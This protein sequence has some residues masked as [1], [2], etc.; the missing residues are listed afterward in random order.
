MLPYWLS[1][2]P[3]AL[4]SLTRDF[5]VD[6][7]LGP[8]LIALLVALTL[9]VG[10]RYH[11]GA[12]WMGYDSIYRI[13][14]LLDYDQLAQ[15]GDRGFFTLVWLLHSA[16]VEIWLLNLLC[17]LIFMFGLATFARQMPNPWLTVA[18]AL[19]YLIVVVA[20]SGIRQ[21]SAIGLFYMAI[22]AYRERRLMTAVGWLFAAA[23]FHASAII[24]LGVAGLS[25]T[26]NRL[27]G[28]MVILATALVGYYVLSST[29]DTYIVRYGGAQIQSSG[30]IYRV[31]MNMVA[32]VPYLLLSKRI[33]VLGDHERKFWR[34]MS[35]LSIVCLPL[36]AIVPSSTA[37]DR[38]ALYLI[39]LQTFVLT[40]LPA[41]LSHKAKN[42]KVITI[43]ILS[44][45]FFVM[46]IFLGYGV[47]SKAS[48]PYRF[49]PIFGS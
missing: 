12:D 6:R 47:N 35:W 20:M 25:F 2:F 13:T 46:T 14:A 24:M 21:A 42:V 19:P 22:V 43:A 1:F 38:L 34:N 15:F 5:R 7:R 10:L 8:V 9:F 41:V 36:L 29:F 37:L 23:T 31:L 44:Y 48:I 11:V 26:R 4:G 32:A 28:A 17:A 49:Y 18:I 16:E 33:P 39:P 27:Q 3:F 45:L 40:W 30:T